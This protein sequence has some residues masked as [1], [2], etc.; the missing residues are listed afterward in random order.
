VKNPKSLSAE[1][2]EV[3]EKVLTERDAIGSIMIQE[4]EEA[5]SKGEYSM[6]YIGG[7]H[8]LTVI[9]I[10]ASGDFRVNAKCGGRFF[11]VENKDL[12]QGAKE[13]GQ[14]LWSYLDTKFGA[15]GA[16]RDLV[17]LR[18][19]GVVRD[20]EQFILGDAELIEPEILMSKT[21]VLASKLSVLQP[22]AQ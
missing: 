9:M 22:L 14:R 7:K 13:T 5:I 4:Y 15:Q 18:V 3:L 6:V 20:D 17:Y 8:I 10:P 11:Q 12:P 21:T 1:D 19:D 16:K 2:D